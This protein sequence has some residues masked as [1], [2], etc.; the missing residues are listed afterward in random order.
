M[1]ALKERAVTRKAS[2]GRELAGSLLVHGLLIGG[3]LGSGILFHGKTEK[4]GDSEEL[5][6]AVQ[7]TAVTAIPL[8]PRVPPKEENVLATDR[9]SVAP[10]PPKE[11]AEP[12]PKPTDVPVKVKKPEKEP[13]KKVADKLAPAT[14]KI[15]PPKVVEPQK[16]TSGASGGVRIAMQAVT[17]K[18][19]T[20]AINVTDQSFGAR[21]GY[22][23]RQ[24][25]QRISQQ[26]VTATLDPDAQGRRVYM[27]FRIDRSGQLSEVRI[28]QSSGNRSLDSSAVRTLE[29]IE[30]LAPLP[31]DYTGNY[32]TVQY[33]FEPS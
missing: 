24:M 16:A 3:I 23:V 30:T 13:P 29:R 6:G 1:P 28:V 22:Y 4:W 11:A 2:T 5:A 12:P 33:Y 14:P 26:W 17:N 32:I 8:P 27:T 10:P 19:G 18:V 25:N 7:A 20:S 15:V 21:F 31:E 9:P